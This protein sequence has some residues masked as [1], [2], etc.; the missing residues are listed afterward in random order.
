MRQSRDAR[1]VASVC[2]LCLTSA[3]L[4]AAQYVGQTEVHARTPYTAADPVSLRS[5]SK[6][7]LEDNST[8]SADVTTAPPSAASTPASK[9]TILQAADI[10][11]RL[12]GTDAQPFDNATAQAFQ[13]A[14]HTVFSNFS[15]AAFVF[16]STKVMNLALHCAPCITA[17]Q[18]TTP[19]H[20][21]RQNNSHRTP[22]SDAS[23]S[24]T[25]DCDLSKNL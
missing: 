23:L 10:T 15:S 17:I 19:T 2:L 9:P 25:L 12:V 5:I 4:S 6:R 20:T 11:F 16:Q 1:R 24:Q 7:L 21:H 8:F 3:L 14:L 18:H 13:R 22:R